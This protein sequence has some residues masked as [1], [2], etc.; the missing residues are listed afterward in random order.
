MLAA[1]ANVLR[2]TRC[3][4]INATSDAGGPDGGESDF[5]QFQ[6]TDA[7]TGYYL[8]FTGDISMTIRVKNETYVVEPGK[9]G[10]TLPSPFS[11]IP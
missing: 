9:P 7:S 11:G 10:P 6:L 1:L 8:Q 2:P 3:G 4:V 5:L